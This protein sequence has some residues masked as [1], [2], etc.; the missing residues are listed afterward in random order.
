MADTTPAVA[1]A[2]VLLTPENVAI[3]LPAFRLSLYSK[4]YGEVGKCIRLDRALPA[5]HRPELGDLMLMHGVGIAGIDAYPVDPLTN[6]LT[7]QAR[8][9]LR[10]DLDRYET[11][12]DARCEEQREVIGHLRDHVTERSMTLLKAW[13]SS[14]GAMPCSCRRFTV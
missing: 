14:S 1:A 12:R 7:D 9:N 10:T 8:K 11:L 3:F 5:I 13:A 6:M 4:K 2:L